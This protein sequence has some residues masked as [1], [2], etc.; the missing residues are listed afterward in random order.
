MTNGHQ[1]PQKGTPELPQI[2]PRNL[3]NGSPSPPNRA[4]RAPRGSQN[5]KTLKKTRDPT[6]TQ[7]RPKSVMQQQPKVE[8]TK[9]NCWNQD[10]TKKSH[11]NASKK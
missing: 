1:K 10:R 3:Q 9:S 11:E 8:S 6:T 5:P 4:Q 2:D 7:N